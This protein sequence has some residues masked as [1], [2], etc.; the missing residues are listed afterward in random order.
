[1]ANGIPKSNAFV[2]VYSIERSFWG[3]KKAIKTVKNLTTKLDFMKFNRDVLNIGYS[4][5]INSFMYCFL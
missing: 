3:E 1:M 4:L 2:N 5:N